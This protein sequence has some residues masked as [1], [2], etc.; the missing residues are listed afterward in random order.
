MIALNLTAFR[1]VNAVLGHSAGD[2]LLISMGP[3]ISP[4]LPASATLGRLAGD[5]FIVLLPGV[6]AAAAA[7][8]VAE[9]V[10]AAVQVPFE[11]DGLSVDLEV[12]CGVVLAPQDGDSAASVLRRV[13]TAT[14]V[15]RRSGSG[16]AFYDSQSDVRPRHQLGLAGQV[17]RG[18]SAGELRPHFQPQVDLR[19][20]EVCGAEA[21]VRWYHPTRGV[22]PPA[23]FLDVV[24]AGDL[25]H[26]LTRSV[27]DQ[28]LAAAAGWH[29]VDLDVSVAVNVST[30]C[31]QDRQL[32]PDVLAALE[33]HG[34]AAQRLTLEITESALMAER[35][36]ILAALT[37]L[38]DQGVRL[39]LDDFG[40][41][42]SSLSHLRA[43]PVSEL[44]VD[45]SFVRDMTGRP[46]D[47]R[48]VRTV[49]D[50]AHSL[51]ML[52]V[53]E[54]VED[55]ATLAALADMGCDVAQG[56]FYAPA[57][58]DGRVA[59]VVPGPVSGRRTAPRRPCR[60]A[61]V[62]SRAAR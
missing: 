24:E 9:D 7:Q 34:V 27:L 22:L 15:A 11:L 62:T 3:R 50:L 21:L 36:R 19:T 10:R 2:R 5:E 12:A 16:I 46:T 57:M 48:L 25:I 1:E 4:V 33:R 60:W 39:S 37:N 8:Q 17:R 41:G 56:F 61:C 20:G 32:V 47:A 31:L 6:A 59:G 45:R 43:L 30:R 52:V 58:P 38:T 51:G 53:A 13:E 42:Y 23:A 14:S 49:V 54:G 35:P 26:P 28:A 29:A 55:A 40:T 18:L 44:K